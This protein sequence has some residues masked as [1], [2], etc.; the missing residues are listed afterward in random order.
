MDEQ[1][2]DLSKSAPTH[3]K[4]DT[5]PLGYTISAESAKTLM[6][7]EFSKKGP[8][9]SMRLKQSVI[10]PSENRGKIILFKEANYEIYKL[11]D[12][13]KGAYVILGTVGRI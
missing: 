6:S 8:G 2:A 11:N 1:I 5:Y 13:R 4:M 7:P 12:I 3:Y 9:Y 10:V